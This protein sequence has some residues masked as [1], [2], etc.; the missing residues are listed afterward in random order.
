MEGSANTTSATRL[1][2]E[3]NSIFELTEEQISSWKNRNLEV[4]KLTHFE[5]VKEIIMS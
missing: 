1:L 2:T 5:V 3:K 4:E